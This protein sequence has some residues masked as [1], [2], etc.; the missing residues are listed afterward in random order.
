[1]YNDHGVNF[2]KT[3]DQ[4]YYTYKLSENSGTRCTIFVNG[5]LFRIVNQGICPEDRCPAPLLTSILPEVHLR[6]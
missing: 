6:E 2:I 1:M 5:S 3:H 4:S